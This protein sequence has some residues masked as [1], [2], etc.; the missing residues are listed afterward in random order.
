METWAFGLV[1]VLVLMLLRL[2]IA[3]AMALIGTVGISAIIGWG[4]AFA[5]MGQVSF[6]T[7]LSYELSVVPLFVLM[8]N[9]VVRAGL[10]DEMYEAS[11]S[12]LGQY[13]GGLAM[14]TIVACGGF[15]SVCG[16]SLA[17]AATMTKVA[18]PPMRRY[19]YAES[20]A[21]GAIASGATLGI[22]IP[23]S[24]VMVVY[25]IMTQTDIGALFIAG[26]IPGVIGIAFY[27]FAVAAVTRVNPELG[28]PGPAVSFRRK[29][30]ATRG[31]LGVT[32]LFVVVIGGIYLGIF[33]ATEAA[34]IGAAGSFFLAL[35]RKAL[36]W[37]SLLAVLEETAATSAMMFFVLIGALIFSNYV[38]LAG[39]PNALTEWVGASELSPLVVILG[40]LVI[41]IALGCVLESMSMVLLTVPIFY[42]VVQALGFDGIWFGILVVVVTEISLI[43]PPVGMN[44]FVL[45]SVLPEVSTKTIFKGV[46]PFLASDFV[47]LALLVFVPSIVTFLPSLMGK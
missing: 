14:A 28:P 1:A 26:I 2:P 19:G 21:T 45:R 33:T 16:S 29:L 34:G 8:G 10:S 15:S 20:L 31:V 7:V 22:L 39:L 25:G 37:R 6:D 5:M 36:T 3:F 18:M 30:Q 4:P 43:S 17:T 9:F 24:V 41:Y 23:P 47:R 42:P 11:Y 13:R 38:N 35:F 27:V 40:I 46:M 12:W 44:V 32:M